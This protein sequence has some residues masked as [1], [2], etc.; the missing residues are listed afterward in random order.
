MH[1]FALHY[2]SVVYNLSSHF[3]HFAD[4]GDTNIVGSFEQNF[5]IHTTLTL[6]CEYDGVPSPNITW[7]MNGTQ[8]DE[9]N[10][11]ITITNVTLARYNR[12]TTLTWLNIPLEG[13]GTYFCITSNLRGTDNASFDVLISCKF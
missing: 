1:R 13:R 12:T 5:P 2:F 9:T 4:H 11:N 7:T 3:P 10:P 6:T 8:L